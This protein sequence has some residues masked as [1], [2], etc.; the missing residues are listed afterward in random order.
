MSKTINGHIKKKK[1]QVYFKVGIKQDE[2][3]R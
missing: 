2:N 3:L 1:N